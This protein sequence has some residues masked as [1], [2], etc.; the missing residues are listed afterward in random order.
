MYLGDG[1]YLQQIRSP[2]NNYLMDEKQAAIKLGLVYKIV[3]MKT[4]L[5]MQ[6]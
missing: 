5:K 1:Y 2:K 3:K 6:R 4:N